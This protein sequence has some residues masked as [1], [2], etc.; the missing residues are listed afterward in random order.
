MKILLKECTYRSDIIIS[1]YC[2]C[3][4]STIIN[5]RITILRLIFEILKSDNDFIIILYLEHLGIFGISS[6]YQIHIL[7]N[8]QSYEKRY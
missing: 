6:K 7:T 5:S 4:I 2:T 8:I 3:S 1:D